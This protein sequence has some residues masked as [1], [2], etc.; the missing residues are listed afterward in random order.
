MLPINTDG[1]TFCFY[2]AYSVTQLQPKTEETAGGSVVSEG[3]TPAGPL[4]PCDTG[5]TESMLGL[6]NMEPEREMQDLF[7]VGCQKS[8]S[9]L[10][11]VLRGHSR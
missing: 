9:F 3:V 6:L 7:K 11:V 5:C 2:V 1:D 10:V 4:P 8:I